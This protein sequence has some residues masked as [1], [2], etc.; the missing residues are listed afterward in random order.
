VLL[1]G[2]A[3]IGKSRH[4]SDVAARAAE[5]GMAVA[6]PDAV[7]RVNRGAAGA[8]AITDAE[9]ALV[10]VLDDLQWADP[11]TLLTIQRLTL[12][13]V[14]HPLLWILAGRR[15]RGT[16]LDRLHSLL[17]AAVGASRLRLAPLA[18]DAV[19]EVI[20]D[21]L[22]ARPDAGLLAMAEGAGGNPL[23]VVELMEGLRDEGSVVVEHGQARL[24][25]DQLPRR[26]EASVAYRLG[27]LSPASLH[28]LEVGAVLGQSFAVE[29]LASALGQPVAD[30]V[31]PLQELV[32]AGVLVPVSGEAMGFHH[33]LVRQTIY[34]A[35][36]EPT[37]KAL[38]REIGDRLLAHHPSA[39]LAAAHL[40]QGARPGDGEALAALDRAVNELV[41]TAP[42]AAADMAVRAWRLTEASDDAQVDR[43]VAA[44]HA[45]VGAGRVAEALDVAGHLP[46]GTDP[47]LDGAV[48]SVMLTDGRL[49]EA[50]ALAVAAN[51]D[52]TCLL[53]L[54]IMGDAPAVRAGAEP[55][56]AAG[57]EAALAAALVAMA[58]LA[59]DEGRVA[60]ALALGRAA[61]ARDNDGIARSPAR[62]LLAEMLTSVDQWGEAEA[63]L[64]VDVAPSWSPGLALGRGRLHLA[65]GRWD[66]AASEATAG[67][68]LAA[69]VAGRLF[70]T[71]LQAVLAHEPVRRSPDQA[72]SSTRAALAANDQAQAATAVAHAEQRAAMSPE[73][74]SVAAAAWHARGLA[75]DDAD[76][77][78]RAAGRHRRPWLR[79]S[80]WE[81]AGK[82]SGPEQ[83]ERALAAYE[84]MG[85]EHDAARVRARLRRMGVRRRHWVREDRPLTGWNSLTDT[86][87]R[88]A[89]HVADGLTNAQ[90]A[91]H[92]FLSRHTIDF[93]LRQIFRKLAI[94]SRVDLA[95][96]ALGQQ[97]Q[98]GER[99]Q[100]TRTRDV[101]APPSMR[102]STW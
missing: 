1:E 7:A 48:A 66:E 16:P 44:V 97:G 69:E 75:D 36:P 57:D 31:K 19:T 64:A 94:S 95:R 34:R 91:E 41:A 55:L 23:L 50:L 6:G 14:S 17:E 12:E 21:V 22:G 83:L 82:L 42:A 78:V 59:W 56:L 81:D 84:G 76:L 99:G 8:T 79:A 92:M 10:I 43:V 68:A 20:V 26:V 30:T 38:H 4:L 61:V 73:F 98:Q 62:L 32:D 71:G 35:M 33:N 77:L 27:A 37:R 87:R 101:P 52:V 65:M 3:G 5:T 54:V 89:A 63:V 72:V 60:D 2:P 86:E 45:L 102:P 25:S 18:P 53:A 15:V 9:S 90:A 29:D 85:A 40:V 11:A 74:P 46:M 93:H 88:V 80:A 39:A 13:L 49:D 58:W 96:V 100:T 67:L 70:V 47:R 51:D 28:L 24:L